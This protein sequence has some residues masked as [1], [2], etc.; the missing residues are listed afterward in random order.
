MSDSQPIEPRD[1]SNSSTLVALACWLSQLEGV[2][3]ELIYARRIWSF[4]H[5]QLIR[6][7]SVV[8]TLLA[9]AR[10]LSASTHTLEVCTVLW[11]YF[12]APAPCSRNEITQ[13]FGFGTHYG[14][15]FSDAVQRILSV[16]LSI[17][18]AGGILP[19]ALI[20]ICTVY[21]IL[22]PNTK[23]E[24]PTSAPLIL[25]QIGAFLLL[26][27]SLDILLAFYS[28]P[29]AE[30]YFIPYTIGLVLTLNSS[31]PSLQGALPYAKG[32]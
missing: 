11:I 9:L 23:L 13:L 21:M 8:I 5:S 32:V 19:D 24:P 2:L 4:S 3:V 17:W 22:R 18:T 30:R 15:P 1:V 28:A 14:D 26:C 12:V 31:R 25:A 7:V 20:F 27:A 6:V 29:S 16:E 10:G